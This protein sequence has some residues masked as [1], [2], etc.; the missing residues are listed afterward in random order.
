MHTMSEFLLNSTPE[1]LNPGDV[2]SF[3]DMREL[4]DFEELLA[5]L[6]DPK[7]NLELWQARPKIGNLLRPPNYNGTPRDITLTTMSD[8][9]DRL[10]DARERGWQFSHKGKIGAERT[11]P[12]SVRGKYIG[13]IF[14]A[15]A[16]STDFR[17]RGR[18]SAELWYYPTSRAIHKAGTKASSYITKDGEKHQYLRSKDSSFSKGASVGESIRRVVTRPKYDK[19]RFAAAHDT[20]R[21]VGFII[22]AQAMR[23][24]VT[25]PMRD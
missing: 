23:Q 10:L 19:E 14:D 22:L 16:H 15:E 24:A 18:I 13:F 21:S 7:A 9:Y 5:P 3:A 17:K 20:S 25:T 11:E 8:P 1:G 6:V 4:M 12:E 2:I